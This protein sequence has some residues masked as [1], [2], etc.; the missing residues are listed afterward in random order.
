VIVC[1]YA[2]VSPPPARLTVTGVAGE[3]LQVL[4]VGRIGAIVGELRRAPAPSVR[5]LRR[6]AAAVESVAAK[7]SAILPAR[8]GTTVTDA[9]ELSFIIRSRRTA[10]RQRLSAVRGRAQ[11][12]IRLIESESGDAALSSQSRVTGRTQ[13]RLG[14][15]TT[16]GTQ[17]LRQKMADA[18]AACAVPAFDVVRP[19]IQR[20][21]KD[22]RVEKRDG[23]V[24]INHLVPHGSVERYR[25]AVT[26]TAEDCGVRLIVTGP[27]APYA[28]AD[29][30]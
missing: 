8:F 9:D 2:L 27:W 15:G 11:M 26:R 14:Y 7:T 21:V 3:R 28:F 5:N 22:E 23:I 20:Y 30:W 19:A 17:Y 6:Y 24:T 1:V 25:D 13:L 29:T 4:R 16:Q 10:L 12:T 18:A